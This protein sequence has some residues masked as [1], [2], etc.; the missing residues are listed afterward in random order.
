M[1]SKEV[2]LAS[3]AA[4]PPDR[5]RLQF[6][7]TSSAASVSWQLPAAEARLRPAAF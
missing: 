6:Q 1:K 4:A 3:L 7:L 2:S 5:Q